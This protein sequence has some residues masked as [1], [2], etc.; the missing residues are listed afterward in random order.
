MVFIAQCL[1]IQSIGFG[2]YA[3]IAFILRI[4]DRTQSR[5]TTYITYSLHFIAVSNLVLN[6]AEVVLVLTS[7]SPIAKFW[8]PALPGSCNHIDRTKQVGYFQ[9][10][11]KYQLP[12]PRLSR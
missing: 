3:V 11:R 4:Q 2:K 9:P 10:C 12:W 1:I 7:C 6:I 8:N 5:K